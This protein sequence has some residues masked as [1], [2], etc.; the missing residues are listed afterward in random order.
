[1]LDVKC[2]CKEILPLF[3]G[4]AVRSL[5]V[6]EFYLRTLEEFIERERSHEV[7]ELKGHADQLPEDRQGE[8]WAWHYPVH[9]DEIFASQLRSSFVVTLVSLA[10]SHV[11]MVAEQ[12]REI[13]E[14]P[15][16]PGDLRGGPLE[17]HRKCLQALAGFTQPDDRSWN[18]I[19]EIRDVRNCIVHANSRIR[20]AKNDVRLRS[21]VG[22]L[23]GLTAP[24]DV[25]ELSKEFPTHAFQTVQKFI[26]D[27]YEE[28]KEL[29]QRTLSKSP[30]SVP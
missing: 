25:L 9:W 4:D 5:Q 11:G 1:M 2:R 21:L 27:L 18:A 13:A 6:L 22:K 19:Y 17:R 23:P 16:K 29:C 7:S 15:L 8:F 28:A 10:E 12:A 3:R 24:Y 14:T 26:L 30:G 20:E